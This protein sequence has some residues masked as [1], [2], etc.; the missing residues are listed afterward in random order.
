[1]TELS[2]RGAPGCAAAGSRPLAALGGRWAEVL[3]AWR[4]PT[5][6]LI[7]AQQAVEACRRPTRPCCER[8]GVPLLGLIQWGGPFDGRPAAARDSP[9]WGRWL[10][11][12]AADDDAELVL[13]P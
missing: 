10:R 7:A 6:L 11:A 4:Q 9:G 5:V 3:G 8:C 1:M 13:E 2:G 12:T